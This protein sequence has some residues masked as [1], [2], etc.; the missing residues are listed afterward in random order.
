MNKL[1]WNKAYIPAI[2]LN[3]QETYFWNTGVN[4][5]NAMSMHARRR[6]VRALRNGASSAGIVDALK[7]TYPSQITNHLSLTD[8]GYVIY[9]LKAALIIPPEHRGRSKY[10]ATRIGTSKARSIAKLLR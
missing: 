7:I 8:L 1:M 2:P 10:V 5:F 6:V 4:R 3:T 9:A